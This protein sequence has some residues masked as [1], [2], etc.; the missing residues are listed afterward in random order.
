MPEEE[1]DGRAKL[2]ALF[3][4]ALLEIAEESADVPAD[5]P[6]ALDGTINELRA[7]MMN[8]MWPEEKA[9]I[10]TDPAIKSL[11]A[12]EAKQQTEAKPQVETPPADPQSQYVA[13]EESLRRDAQVTQII[14]EVEVQVAEED[15]QRQADAVWEAEGWDEWEEWPSEDQAAAA[16]APQT[17]PTP[18][19]AAKERL[20]QQA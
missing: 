6:T 15:R 3:E 14:E 16:A 19:V 12:A 10:L 18:D 20:V 9:L 2:A 17:A 7:R 5:A 8:D 4:A 1:E 13:D 11:A